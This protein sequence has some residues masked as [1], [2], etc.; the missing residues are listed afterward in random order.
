MARFVTQRDYAFFKGVNKELV[1]DIINTEVIIFSLDAKDNPVNIYNES[2]EKIYRAGVQCNALITHD[3]QETDDSQFGPDIK[4]NIVCG[5]L[6][7]DL[8]DKNFYP[9]RGDIIKWNDAYYEIG[10]VV[11]NQLIAGRV[12]MP[13]SIICT[14]HMTNR[15]TINIREE[16]E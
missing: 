4:Q 14:A 11:D 1:N 6:R 13:Y 16:I 12:G 3:D 5:F 9:E 15:S 10:G 7:R 2:I 8:E